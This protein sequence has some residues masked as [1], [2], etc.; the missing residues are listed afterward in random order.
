MPAGSGKAA[1]ASPAHSPV[2]GSR[3]A[4]A[5]PKSPLAAEGLKAASVAL[6]GRADARSLASRDA[7]PAKVDP[8]PPD[9]VPESPARAAAAARA[10]LLRF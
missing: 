7:S 2:V 5:K 10:G 8:A 4:A 6:A 1:A 3:P 9:A